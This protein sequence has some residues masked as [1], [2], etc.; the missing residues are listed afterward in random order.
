MVI[1]HF[2]VYVL[3]CSVTSI[4]SDSVIPSTVARQAPLSM[5]IPRQEYWSEMPFPSPGY[6]PNPGIETTSPASPALQ[7]DS[8]P[9][10]PPAKPILVL[11]ALDYSIY[12]SPES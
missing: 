8:L 7:A 10:E 12:P 9:T 11:H 4:V 6:L 5:G 3:A 1:I 2:R